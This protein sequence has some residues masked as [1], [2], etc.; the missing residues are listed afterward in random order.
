VSASGNS[1]IAITTPQRPGTRRLPGSSAVASSLGRPRRHAG[2]PVAVA[3]QPSC[4]RAHGPQAQPPDLRPSRAS[5]QPPA[6]LRHYLA[7]RS[8]HSR[9]P[10]H[11]RTCSHLCLLLVAPALPSGQG[12]QRLFQRAHGGHHRGWLVAAMRHAVGAPRVTSAQLASLLA[13]A[14]WREQTPQAAGPLSLR[15]S[16]LCLP[17]QPSPEQKLMPF[18]RRQAGT[19]GANPAS[20]AAATRLRSRRGPR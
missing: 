19:F 1:A 6:A 17:I 16:T 11:I 15:P 8:N 5:P 7:Y 9:R 4:W 18:R 14:R 10:C 12:A 3:V 13:S 20:R 2:T